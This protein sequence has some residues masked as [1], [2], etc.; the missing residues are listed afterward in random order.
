MDTYV[1]EIIA[2]IKADACLD[3]S[4]VVELLKAAGVAVSEVNDDEGVIG[5]TVPTSMLKQIDA[6]G[7]VDYVRTVFTYNAHS[8]EPRAE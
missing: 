2:V 4:K 3:I 1:S 7:C 8:D 6:L 5:G